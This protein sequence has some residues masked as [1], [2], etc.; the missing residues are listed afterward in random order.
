[1]TTG[2][3][4]NSGTFTSN[5][6]VFRSAST[7]SGFTLASGSSSQ[8]TNTT[9]SNAT[10]GITD[11]SS[12]ANVANCTFSSF[13]L[14]TTVNRIG[15]NATNSNKYTSNKYQTQAA[16]LEIT[17]GS[18]VV[19]SSTFGQA[20]A[21]PLTISGGSPQL[22]NNSFSFNNT[23]GGS[24]VYISGGTPVFQNNTVSG[25]SSSSYALNI[26]GS[27]SI[28][29]GNFLN[30]NFSAANPRVTAGVGSVV[31]LE[32]NYWGAAKPSTAN[33][34][35]TAE[36][37][38]EPWRNASG[39]STEAREVPQAVFNITPASGTIF[40]SG[41]SSVNFSLEDLGYHNGTPLQYGIQIANNA[42]F[43]SP[44]HSSRSGAAY[45]RGGA[46]THTFSAIN[47]PGTYYWRVSVNN[48]TDTAGWG[49][50]PPA[51]GYFTFSIRDSQI[52]L[53]LAASKTQASA[54]EQVNY[55]LNFDN[56]ESF[57]FSNVKLTAI[58]PDDVY[59]NGTV[60]LSNMQAMGSVT[61]QAYADLN[62]TQALG[63]Y[64]G[65]PGSN[66][67]IP[68]VSVPEADNH[69]VR[70]FD[71]TITTLSASGSGGSSGA[72][73]YQTLVK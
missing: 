42:N 55:T 34:S 20:A 30:N 27:A 15:P 41:V 49:A 61:V 69:R 17:G 54:G 3:I 64:T 31:K 19:S 6:D 16:A 2:G 57:A 58:L 12:S 7:W 65:V 23:A 24:A 36:I 29:A 40:T 53:T 11:Q 62:G 71:V 48:T 60:Q 50:Y 26:S 9:I 67:F 56:P 35:G 63:S 68:P 28:P 5:T 51:P 22:T 37:D 33:F 38:Y 13:G 44:L 39:G 1:M 25:Y 46:A 8:I 32:N 70:R 21:R 14:N 59:W 10:I 4:T 72:F 43:T 52:N 66:S 18:P 73:T 47:T 45:P